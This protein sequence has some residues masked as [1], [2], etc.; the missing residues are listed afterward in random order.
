MIPNE[1][2]EILRRASQLSQVPDIWILL[3]SSYRSTNDDIWYTQIAREIPNLS[4]ARNFVQTPWGVKMVL[5]VTC[6]PNP[7]FGLIITP[8]THLQ[9]KYSAEIWS[10]TLFLGNEG[11]ILML[12]YNLCSSWVV[13]LVRPLSGPALSPLANG[14]RCNAVFYDAIVLNNFFSNTLSAISHDC[15]PYKCMRPVDWESTPKQ[16]GQCTCSTGTANSQGIK[17]EKLSIIISR[18]DSYSSEHTRSST[19]EKVF[20]NV[21][22]SLESS[23][24]VHGEREAAKALIYP[25]TGC[26]LA[27]LSVSVVLIFAQLLLRTGMYI[28]ERL[29]NVTVV[30]SYSNKPLTRRSL[31]PQVLHPERTKSSPWSQ[32]ARV[33]ELTYGYSHYLFGCTM[34]MVCLVC[35]QSSIACNDIRGELSEFNCLHYDQDSSTFN[36]NCSFTWTGGTSKCL[37]LQKNETFEGN[38]HSIHLDGVTNWEGLFQ[39]ATDEQSPSSLDDAPVIHDVHMIGGETSTKGGFIIQ[40][41][42]KHFIVKNCSSSGVIQGLSFVSGGG[43]CGQQCSGDILITHCWSTGEIRTRAG[44]I[45]GRELGIDGDTDNTVTISHCYCTGD[46]VGENSGGICGFR[47]GH[48]NK[49]MVIIKQCYS[50]G[51]IRGSGSG[52]IT[53][54]TTARDG[55]HVSIINCYSRGD[56]TGP[57][58]AGGICGRFTGYNG[59]TVILTNVYASGTIIGTNAGGLIG[60]IFNNANEINITMSVYNG[61]TGDMIG[62]GSNDAHNTEKNSGDLGDITGTVYCY[63]DDNTQCWD[64]DTV[65][66]VVEEEDF[67]T[68]QDMPTPLPSATPSPTPSTSTSTGTKTNTNTPS[69]TALSTATATRTAS[70]TGSL[71]ASR[72]SSETRTVTSSRLPTSSPSATKTTTS[73]QSGTLSSR[74]TPSTSPTGTITS[75]ETA[76]PTETRTK[77]ASPSATPTNKRKRE[78]MELSVQ[79]PPRSVIMKRGVNKKKKK[80]VT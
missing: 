72:T 37:V 4:P 34:L 10:P 59:G 32:K 36:M 77:T 42:Q 27:A 2:V 75:T 63:N 71:T 25:H 70:Q 55:G 65:W 26:T 57:N 73:S 60:H 30:C 18:P 38:G 43:I 61:D 20:T 17:D 22:D 19:D 33:K 41:K 45:A 3:I 58:N 39:I 7:S 5:I 69:Q 48:N 11:E 28:K 52:G 6:C 51:E 80:K 74:G 16:R 50:L 78:Q 35:H 12:F 56:I 15:E 44:G 24:Q 79:Y 66:Q 1:R 40:S 8:D 9:S 68:L 64:T 53:G 13:T 14:K 31:Q 67:P 21:K 23:S 54:A 47:V 76:S 62:G 46:I 49:G 29:V